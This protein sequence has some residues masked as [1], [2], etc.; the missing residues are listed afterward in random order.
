MDWRPRVDAVATD[1][2]TSPS[3]PDRRGPAAPESCAGRSPLPAGAWRSCAASCGLTRLVRPA[4]RDASTASHTVLTEM[5]WSC[6]ACVRSWGTD[7]CAAFSSA[8]L[9]QRVEQRRTE[10]NL[11]IAPPLPRSTR[12]IMRWLSMSLSFKRDTSVRR[13]GLNSLRRKQILRPELWKVQ[14]PSHCRL[15]PASRPQG[16]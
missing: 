3:S 2:G 12:I 14:S 6:R 7:R 1:A 11:A 10:R 8:I 13:F 16:D 4:W 5:G 15:T 9:T